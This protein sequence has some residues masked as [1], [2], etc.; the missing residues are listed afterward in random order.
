MSTIT[1]PH[2]RPTGRRVDPPTA[3]PPIRRPSIGRPADASTVDPPTR[4]PVDPS[5]RRPVD[6]PTR[7]ATCPPRQEA[8]RIPPGVTSPASLRTRQ[9]RSRRPWGPARAYRECVI[10]F[11]ELCAEALAA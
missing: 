8:G 2:R 1:A 6:P 9:A 4:G 3:D 5:I 11:D 10:T 7:D